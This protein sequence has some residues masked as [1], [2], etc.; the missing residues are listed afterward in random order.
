MKEQIDYETEIDFEE[1][2]LDF[3]VDF[4]QD[5]IEEQRIHKP[6]YHKPFKTKNIKYDNAEKLSD[7]IGK[8]EGRIYCILSGNFI[9]GDFL[10]AF[11]VKRNL[12]I[13]RMVISTLSM[14]QENVDSLENLL[15][16]GYVDSLDIM[17]SS[18]F[19]GHERSK[20]IPYI[21]DRLDSEQN[22]FQ[23]SVSGNHC[24]FVL[25]E[26]HCGKKIVIHGSSNLRSSNCIEQICIEANEELFDF[27]MEFSQI[28]I[29]K[30][31][32]INKEITG[33]R[34]KKLWHSLQ[35]EH[36]D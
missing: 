6:K 30:F 20:L 35:Q 32:T 23:L 12:H 29:D 10:E 17:I 33:N 1:L 2:K 14:S 18:Y 28:I 15:K 36:K 4:G 13:K 3:D 5:L 25:I 22:N 11:A 24:K 9:F 16:G 26:T 27:N 8:I 19:W 7:D 31:N 34:G 21:F